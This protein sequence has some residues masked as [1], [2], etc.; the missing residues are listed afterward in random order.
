AGEFV[1]GVWTGASTLVADVYDHVAVWEAGDWLDTWVRD[2]EGIR[3]AARLLADDPQQFVELVVDLE[4]LAQSPARWSGERLTDVA[5]AF[6]GAAATARL[7]SRTKR[8]AD[9][10]VDVHAQV[11]RHLDAV[12]D[13]DLSALRQLLDRHPRLARFA[14]VRTTDGTR[15]ALHDLGRRIGEHDLLV[16]EG[17][18]TRRNRG[19][20]VSTHVARTDQQLQRR[21]ELE[22]R[23]QASTFDTLRG[24]QRLR[25]RVVAEFRADIEAWLASGDPT[26]LRLTYT[27]AQPVG[28]VLQGGAGRSTTT[29]RLTIK[30]RRTGASEYRVETMYP[31]PD[32]IPTTRRSHP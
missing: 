31:V 4:G 2:V 17:L 29:H 5:A 13:I 22:S 19:H 24:A 15:A 14:V 18:G 8:T 32:P 10:V 12:T 20:T 16:Q 9:L 1:G 6:T 28:R 30:L 25:D 11:R 3:L 23:P 26:P 21:I 7:A 27:A